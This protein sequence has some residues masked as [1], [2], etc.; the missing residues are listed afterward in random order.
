MTKNILITGCNGQLGRELKEL[1]I[2]QDDIFST[3]NF[4]FTNRDS[5]DITNLVKLREY[6]E[7]KKIDSIVNCAA[8]TAVDDAEKNHELAYLINTEAVKNMAELSLEKEIRL[9]HI[10]TDYVFEDNKQA[11]IKEEDST[12][13]QSIYAKSKLAG[14]EAIE[15]VNPPNSIII[16]TSWLYSPFG[17]NFVNTMLKLGKTKRELDVVCDQLGTPTY[18]KDLAIVILKIL[19]K[20]IEL[21]KSVT[22]YNYSNEG[23][24]SM[25]DFAQAI[26]ELENIKCKVNPILTQDY[27]TPSKRPAYSVL[28]KEKIKKDFNIQIPYWR[29]SLKDCLDIINIGIPKTFKIGIIG[30]GFIGGGLAKLLAEH[31]DYDISGVLTR[32]DLSKRNDFAQHNKLTNSLQDLIESSDLIVECS[33]DAIY[34]TESIDSIL[35]ASIPVVTMNSEFHVTTGSYFVDKGLVTEAEGDQPGVL[36]ILSEEAL[37]MGF[38]P[39]VYANIKGFLNENPTIEDMTYWGNKSNLSL[40]MVTSFTDGTKVEIEQVL[41]ANGLGAGLIQ[42]GLVKLSS[43]DMLEGGTILADKAKELGYPVSDYLLSSKL[44]AG[45]FLMVEHDK[46]QQASLKYYKLG[47]GPYYVLERTYHLCHFEI[48]KTIRRV[49]DGGGVLLNNGGNPKFSVAAVAKRDLKVGEKIEKG[50]GSFEVRGTAIEI[51]NDLS[52]VPIGLLANATFIKDVKEGDKVRFSD[53][54]IP[55][56]LALKVWQKIIDKIK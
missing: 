6:V 20:D 17:T 38:K 48:I 47:D 46:D 19:N 54:D 2:K 32:S 45:V 22:V 41:V 35:K 43:D 28:S 27:P 29:E 55:E 34:A 13:P 33:G 53:I 7:S 26:F 36:A 8:Y 37:Q 23:S 44:P 12:D 3:L 5:L 52:H 50:I 51:V 21:S 4:H 18:T 49:L 40:P 16:R 1:V 10:S 56:S 11:P 42:E 14:E 24:C 9:I 39:L 15:R 31:K 25:Y 30:S